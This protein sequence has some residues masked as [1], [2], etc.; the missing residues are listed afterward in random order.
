MIA[1]SWGTCPA[2]FAAGYMGVGVSVG[3]AGLGLG[4]VGWGGVGE[5]G[6]MK[7]T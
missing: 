5:Q 6:N 7:G 1:D 3:G 4:G 2:D